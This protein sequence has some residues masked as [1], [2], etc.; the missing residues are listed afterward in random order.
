[1][2]QYSSQLEPD[3]LHTH[4]ASHHADDVPDSDHAE[5]PQWKHIKTRPIVVINAVLLMATRKTSEQ[6]SDFQKIRASY[7][8]KRFWIQ[9]WC[10]VVFLNKHK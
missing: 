8:F 6:L 2:K 7:I 4:Y 1:M 9:R 10:Y 3:T 5:K